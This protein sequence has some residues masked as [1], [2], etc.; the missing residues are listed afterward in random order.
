MMQLQEQSLPV[1]H[2]GRT[3]NTPYK[4]LL[5]SASLIFTSHNVRKLV[6]MAHSLTRHRDES[7]CAERDRGPADDS[8]LRAARWES[9]AREAVAAQLRP[10]EDTERNSI[11]K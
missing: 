10:G 4:H 11:F 1:R 9:A 6:Q 5:P 7:G 2:T 3:L 8:S